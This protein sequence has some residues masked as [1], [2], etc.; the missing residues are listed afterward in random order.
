MSKYI[1]VLD[2][3]EKK[4]KLLYFFPLW[5]LTGSSPAPSVL[6][7]HR[8]FFYRILT[9]LVLSTWKAQQTDIL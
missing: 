7:L 4:K 5:K 8:A 2:L 1:L 9:F 6:K 3:K